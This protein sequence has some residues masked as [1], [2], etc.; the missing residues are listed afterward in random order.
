M[1]DSSKSEI[2]P[3]LLLYARVLQ[4]MHW[5]MGQP[6]SRDTPFE[7]LLRLGCEESNVPYPGEKIEAALLTSAARLASV[8]YTTVMA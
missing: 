2:P 1:S 4:F 8:P 7:E 6:E 5:A 3:E